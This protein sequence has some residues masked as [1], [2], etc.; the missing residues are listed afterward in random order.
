MCLNREEVQE[1]IRDL[2][3]CLAAST[4]GA[5]MHFCL[6]HRWGKQAPAH[7]HT[8]MGTP[9]RTFYAAL[10]VTAPSWEPSTGLQMPSKERMDEQVVAHPHNGTHYGT[11]NG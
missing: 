9:R 11:E 5:H 7:R 8:C 3:N 1:Q 6:V 2:E 4:K 10:S